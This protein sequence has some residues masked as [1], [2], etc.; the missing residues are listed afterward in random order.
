MSIF[1]S[2]KVNPKI[3]PQVAPQVVTLIDAINIINN[4]MNSLVAPF[5]AFTKGFQDTQDSIVSFKN[6][7]LENIKKCD[8][9]ESQNMELKRQQIRASEVIEFLKADIQSLIHCDTSSEAVNALTN[10]LNSANKIIEEMKHDKQEKLTIALSVTEEM[11]LEIISLKQENQDL[12]LEIKEIDQEFIDLEAENKSLKIEVDANKAKLEKAKLL[13]TGFIDLMGK[14]GLIP[15][16]IIQQEVVKV[17]EVDRK[18]TIE[19]LNKLKQ[20]ILSLDEELKKLYLESKLKSDDITKYQEYIAHIDEQIIGKNEQIGLLSAKCES[21]ENGEKIGETKSNDVVSGVKMSKK[22]KTDEFIQEKSDD[23]LAGDKI[24]NDRLAS[25]PGYI[26]TTTTTVITFD[27][28]GINFSKKLLEDLEEIKSASS[29][30]SEK[31][32]EPSKNEKLVLYDN[33]K[34]LE[35]VISM[36]K[37]AADKI[38]RKRTYKGKMSVYVRGT[39]PCIKTD[40]EV[41]KFAK[42]FNNSIKFYE[43]SKLNDEELSRPAVKT[44]MKTFMTNVKNGKKTACFENLDS[45]DDL[46]EN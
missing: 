45:L 37:V 4:R 5:E 10:K 22:I 12:V 32:K 7:L 8:D 41:Y 14:F 40:E 24:D 16:G 18:E 26:G 15:E 38:L 9:L 25:A 28:D 19:E 31:H 29:K 35:K 17:V 43:Q 21:F 11:K 34:E 33:V 13:E 23:M 36:N 20:D 42:K 39:Y 1:N 44:G 46:T 30:N 3:N 27:N 2:N 6:I